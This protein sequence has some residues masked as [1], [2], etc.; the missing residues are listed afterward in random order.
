M[1][2]E[3]HLF[4]IIS[5]NGKYSLNVARIIRGE[6]KL[7]KDPESTAAWE[8]VLQKGF[9]DSWLKIDGKPLTGE[10]IQRLKGLAFVLPEPDIEDGFGE[11]PK[12]EPTLGELIRS[13]YHYGQTRC[14]RILKNRGYKYTFRQVRAEFEKQKLSPDPD[15]Q[16]ISVGLAASRL[17][18]GESSVLRYVK[19]NNIHLESIGAYR[20]MSRSSFKKM[21]AYY[22]QIGDRG[23]TLPEAAAALDIKRADVHYYV[24][25]G[26]VDHLKL[27]V[28]FYVTHQGLMDL[29]NIFPSV[30]EGYISVNEILKMVD[31]KRG[32][33]VGWIKRYKVPNIRRGQVF[34]AKRDVIEE[35]VRQKKSSK[36]RKSMVRLCQ[37]KQL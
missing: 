29:R 2:S 6:L 36:N 3:D 22:E 34:Y 32:T 20:V 17:K 13:I 4:Q 16:G 23:I 5:D 28:R 19:R 27:G 24:T 37:T 35:I 11:D 33:I 1:A 26:S 25:N 9:D 30:P 8:D 18:I 21:K 10:N 14:H 12:P 15:V 31:F 7:Y